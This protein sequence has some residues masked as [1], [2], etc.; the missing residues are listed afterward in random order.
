ME[1]RK[2]GIDSS[3]IL[4]NLCSVL[5]ETIDKY[6]LIVDGKQMIETI[7]SQPNIQIMLQIIN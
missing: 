2:K 6:Y 7:I 1:G 5:I 3:A 4:E